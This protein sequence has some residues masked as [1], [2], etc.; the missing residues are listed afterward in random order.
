MPQQGTEAWQQYAAYWA[1]YGYDVNDPQC[2]CFWA[3]RSRGE[4]LIS[5]SPGMAGFA[6]RTAAGG[7][8]RGMRMRSSS[9]GWVVECWSDGQVRRLCERCMMCR[10]RYIILWFATGGIRSLN[11]PSLYPS[12]FLSRLLSPGFRAF[13]STF[14]SHPRL[15]PTSSVLLCPPFFIHSSGSVGSRTY[16]CSPSRGTPPRANSRWC[17][18]RDEPGR[19]GSATRGSSV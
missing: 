18:R 6:V 13:L 8:A 12:H 5:R 16:L 3:I 17:P 14:V 11:Y 1:A 4:R 7:S 9:V 19:E 2:E 10:S 15:P